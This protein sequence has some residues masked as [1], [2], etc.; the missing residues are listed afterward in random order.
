M[1]LR[2][3]T[4]QQVVLSVAIDWFEFPGPPRLTPQIERRVRS[5]LSGFGHPRITP[6]IEWCLDPES[7]APGFVLFTVKVDVVLNKTEVYCSE[8]IFYP[9]TVLEWL[10]KG[11]GD[12][13]VKSE[14]EIFRNGFLFPFYKE[15]TCVGRFFPNTFFFELISLFLYNLN[16][17]S[18][19]VMAETFMKIP[20]LIAI[21]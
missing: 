14:R 17:D 13:S 4:M 18:W 10:M 8:M 1:S 20:I 6:E 5:S 16:Y 12:V 9:G 15:G 7:P 11:F 19:K 21:K 2:I 3:N